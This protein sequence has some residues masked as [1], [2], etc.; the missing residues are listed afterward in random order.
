MLATKCGFIWD[1]EG[2]SVGLDGSPRHIHE[3]CEASLRRLCVEEIDLYYLHRV[4]PRYP[5]KNR[6][7]R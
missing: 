1:G 3:A 5:S 2:K 7:A 4:D 6:S